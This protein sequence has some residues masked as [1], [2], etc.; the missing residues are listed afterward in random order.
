MSCDSIISPVGPTLLKDDAVADAL[1]TL[2]VQGAAALPVVDAAGQFL[3]VFGMREVVGM[4]LPRA[5]LLADG[6][7]LSFVADSIAQLGDRLGRMAGDAV[8]T[9]MAPHR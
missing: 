6:L 8:G 9:H 7:D 5:A 4:L 1:A 2:V 3:G